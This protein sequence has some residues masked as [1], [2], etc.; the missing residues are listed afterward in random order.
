[1]NDIVEDFCSFDISRLLREKGFDITC[2]SAYKCNG[3]LYE[4]WY[5]NDCSSEIGYYA[6]PTYQTAMAWLRQEKGIDCVIEVSDI[7]ARPRKYYAI[8]YDI[9]DKSYIIDLFDSYEEAV[10]ASIK[11]CLTK[12]L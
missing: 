3:E 12:I 5:R 11:Y 4:D 10:E 8:I 9:D 1:M 6:R 2:R 7:T